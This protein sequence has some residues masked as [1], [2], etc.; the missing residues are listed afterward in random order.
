MQRLHY[1][2]GQ[3][4]YTEIHVHQEKEVEQR[5]F[6]SILIVLVY[7]RLPSESIHTS[8]IFTAGEYRIPAT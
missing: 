2:L 6:F 3:K 7:L 8:W 1:L 4:G 5:G